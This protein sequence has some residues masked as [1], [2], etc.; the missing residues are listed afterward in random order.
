MTMSAITQTAATTGPRR[1][2]VTLSLTGAPP[3]DALARPKLEPYPWLS[4]GAPRCRELAEVLEKLGFTVLNDTPTLTTSG[5]ITDLIQQAFALL[6]EADDLFILHVIG[7]CDI[8]ET[9]EQPLKR[10]WLLG[11]DGRRIADDV[12]TWRQR[13]ACAPGR[14]LLVLDVGAAV[15]TVAP[16]AYTHFARD[17]EYWI[18]GAADDDGQTRGGELSRAIIQELAALAGHLATK[19]AQTVL[20]VDAL[21]R[22][23]ARRVPSAVWEPRARLVPT[24]TTGQGIVFP[25]PTVTEEVQAHLARFFAG[26]SVR[27]TSGQ[28]TVSQVL[29]GFLESETLHLLVVTG[30]PGAGKSALVN[31]AVQEHLPEL[32]QLVRAN[33]WGEVRELLAERRLAVVDARDQ[34]VMD[35]TRAIAHQL[36][37]HGVSNDPQ[38]IPVTVIVDSIQRRQARDTETAAS[39]VIVVDGFDEAMNRQQLV[40]QVLCPLAWWEEEK[41]GTRWCRLIVLSRSPVAELEALRP[42]DPSAHRWLDLSGSCISTATLRREFRSYLRDRIYSEQLGTCNGEAIATAMAAALFPS[43]ESAT[44]Q[45]LEWGEHLVAEL[46]LHQLRQTTPP[47]R[48][49][50]DITAFV[51]SLPRDVR[52]LVRLDLLRCAPGLRAIAWALAFAEGDGWPHDLILPIAQTLAPAAGCDP[53]AISDKTIRD[54]LRHDLAFYVRRYPRPRGETTYRLF[55]SAVAEGIQRDVRQAWPNLPGEVT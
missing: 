10:V 34:S 49:P 52:G 54:A 17:L 5:E 37:P 25:V 4:F 22:A 8:A 30:K 29:S 42:R 41:T 16:H 20:D 27:P 19:P 45:P 2:A 6:H 32:S 28:V 43:A 47:P 50:A 38:T 31:N 48:D 55:H 39:P 24:T 3:P 11:P 51:A 33:R 40:D 26:Q 36:D 7:H 53:S 18:V 9:P 35:L 46:W 23:V 1:I 44:S 15:D 12:G 21:L 13:A 14:V